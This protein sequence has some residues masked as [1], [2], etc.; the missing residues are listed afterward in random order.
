MIA[1]LLLTRQDELDAKVIDHTLGL[2]FVVLDEFHTYRGCR[3]DEGL[4][5]G[6]TAMFKA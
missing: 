1:E 3:G 6:L 4:P 5:S 2:R